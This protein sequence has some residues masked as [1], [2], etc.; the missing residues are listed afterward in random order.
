MGALID[1]TNQQFGK[2]TVLYRADNKSGKTYWHCKCECGNEVDVRGASLRNGNTKSCGCLIKNFHTTKED[3]TNKIFGDLTVLYR[4]GTNKQGYALWHCV[5]SC[6]KEIDVRGDCLRKGTRKNCGCL[7]NKKRMIEKINLEGEVFGRLTVL[8]RNGSKNRNAV[9]HCRCDCGNEVDVR[10]D[11]LRNG[12]TN[13]CGCLVSKGEEKIRKILEEL[14][15]SYIQQ[16]TFPELRGVNNGLLKFDFYLPSENV[17]IEYQ[18]K[19]H[20][21]EVESWNNDLT[22]ENRVEHDQRK[23]KYCSNNNIKMIEIPYTD[24]EKIDEEYL[25]RAVY[26]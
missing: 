19:Q 23:R 22:F 4:N 18:G 3:L 16:K 13:S 26:K 2:L 10:S 9:W 1:L 11:A 25:I 14:S 24:F 7:N 15:I 17:V 21:E 12:Q 5:C 6:G 20:Y 8:Y